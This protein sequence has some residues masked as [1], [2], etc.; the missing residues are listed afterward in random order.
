MSNRVGRTIANILHYSKMTQKDCAEQMGISGQYLSDI[1][2]G[3]RKL[4]ARSAVRLSRVLGIDAYKWLEWAARDEL[5][6]FNG[7]GEAT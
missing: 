7:E 5:S 4:S 3:R 6:Y 1:I 2:R